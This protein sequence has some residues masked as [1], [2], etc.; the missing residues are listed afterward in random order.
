MERTL[1]VGLVSD[2]HGLLRPEVRAFLIACDYIVHGGDV[3]GAHILDD[4]AAV[5]PL[6][7]VKGNNDGQPWAAQLRETELIR[8]G[9]IF[10]YVIHNI[11]EL[12]IDPAAAGVRVVVSGHSHKPQIR[13][14]DGILYVNPGSCGPRRF[15]LPVSVGEIIVSGTDAKARIVDLQVPGP[16][17]SP[18]P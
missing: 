7:A 15:K 5:A 4:L 8:V 17:G 3:G 16:P 1:R 10:L 6:V 13:E 2:T 12:D 11:D 9:N 14:H 18:G